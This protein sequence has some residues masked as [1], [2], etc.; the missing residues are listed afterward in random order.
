MKLIGF[1]NNQ[2]LLASY[3]VCYRYLLS[4]HFKHFA[5][6]S[7]VFGV[8]EC[9]RA[10]LEDVDCRRLFV[11]SAYYLEHFVL[12]GIMLGSCGSS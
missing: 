7:L 5:H 12:A 2:D 4:R 11:I 6:T 8:V 10:C 3:V 1:D 9:Y